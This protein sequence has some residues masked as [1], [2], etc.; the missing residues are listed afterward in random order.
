MPDATGHAALAALGRL[1]AKP[2]PADPYPD[3]ATVRACAPVLMPGSGPCYVTGYQEGRA[4]LADPAFGVPDADWY[5]ATRPGWRDRA[6]TATLYQGVQSKN[7]PDHGRMRR[8]L[9]GLFAPRRVERLKD[10]V[11][12]LAD[13]LL[14]DLASGREHDSPVELMSAFAFPLP[15]AVI[16]DLLGV[17]ES[18]RAELARLA[19]AVFAV[20]DVVVSPADQAA[21]DAAATACL[22][23]WR[24]LVA[25][26]RS[27]PAGDLVSEL[28]GACDAGLLSAHEL[29][30]TLTFLQGAGY[31]TTAALIGSAA[32]GLLTD[33]ACA[34]ALRRDPG[35][36]ASVVDEGL[37]HEA[38]TQLTP[39]VAAGG[40]ALAGVPVA[41][42][43]LVLVF[44]GAAN[45]DPRVFA[46]PDVF[47]PSRTEE[48]ALS[49]GGGLHYCLGA[50]L[51]RMEAAAALPRLVRRF[52]ALRLAG[53]PQWRRSLRVRQLSALPVTL[54]P[55][56]TRRTG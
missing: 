18:D 28:T 22:D 21:A 53:P 27:R 41:P 33:P 48:R 39:R 52:P 45:R 44:L 17:P 40:A 55:P 29:L 47:D 56:G 43:R 36:A 15:V 19:A 10:R 24:E 46:R 50:P 11:A 6:A 16:D 49:F 8:A 38:P 54:G 20:T 32:A 37:R 7:P 30:A 51:S 3:Y 13:R 31:G 35:R 1:L 4:V 14:D 23:Y 12:E 25:R 9:G 26:R 5:D 34:A 2:G 42:G